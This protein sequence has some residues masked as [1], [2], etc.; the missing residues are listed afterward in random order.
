MTITIR[1]C[2]DNAAF[3]DECLEGE[4]WRILHR[5]AER[6]RDSGPQDGTPL[7]DANGNTVGEVTI[8]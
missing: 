8:S 2:C 5:L 4:V 3:Q 7:S 1:I 6:I